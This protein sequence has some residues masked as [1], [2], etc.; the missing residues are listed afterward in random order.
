[1]LASYVKKNVCSRPGLLARRLRHPN[2]LH[3]PSRAT[4]L[5]L[6]RQKGMGDVLFAPRPCAS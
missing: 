3:S 2:P 5:D 1:M 6:A 4:Q